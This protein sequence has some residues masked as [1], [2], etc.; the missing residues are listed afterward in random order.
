VFAL[1]LNAKAAGKTVRIFYCSLEIS[2]TEKK[3]KWCSMY[4]DWKYGIQW[5]SGF[6]LGRIP[7]RILTDEELVYVREAYTFIELMLKDVFILDYS[8]SPKL[9]VDYLIE[10]YYSK[11][12]TIV[13][14][15]VSAEDKNKGL[16]G[17]IKTFHPNVDIPLTL[18]VVDHLAL[19]SGG[20]MKEMMD[21]MSIQ[22]VMLRN[23]FGMSVAFIQQFNQELIKARRDAIVRHG[24]KDNPDILAPQQMD[25]GDSTYTFRDADVVLGLVKPARFDVQAFDGFNCSPTH[26]GG[27]GDCLLATYKI[28]DRYG[29]ID[30]VS[31]IFMNGMTGM[32]YDLPDDLEPDLTSYIELAQKLTKIN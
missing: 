14:H 23:V 25:F 27:L 5:S 1:W 10:N 8:V 16:K 6:I 9:I 28:K 20:K 12:G 24:P 15:P 19:L 26:L 31:S 2:A 7:G 21:E 22:A 11:L 3:A 29:P 13:R 32:F 4:L 17:A 18:L 30:K